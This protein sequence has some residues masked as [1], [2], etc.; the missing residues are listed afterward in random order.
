MT[1]STLAQVENSPNPAL[2][3]II[4]KVLEI[5]AS[6]EATSALIRN[7]TTSVIDR[8]DA[9]VRILHAA[10]RQLDQVVGGIEDFDYT[11]PATAVATNRASLS[12]AAMTE[13]RDDTT[14]SIETKLNDICNYVSA[15]KHIVN[16]DKPCSMGNAIDV[17]ASQA[18]ATADSIIIN[19]LQSGGCVGN[20]EEW[21]KYKG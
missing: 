16:Q 19:E 15:I 14:R 18:G 9:A 2:N 12:S 5:S 13:K 1:V 10:R 21:M 7:T 20:Q 6:L 3:A 4:N 17:L 11:T 8:E